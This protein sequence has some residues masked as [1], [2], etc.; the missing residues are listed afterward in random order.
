LD[1]LFSLVSGSHVSRVGFEESPVQPMR[2]ILRFAGPALSVAIS[3]YVGTRIGFLMTPS[4]QPNSTFWPANAILLAAFLLA[5]PRVWWVFVLAVL[6]AHMLA[7]MQSGVPVWT[8]L[9]WFVTNSAEGLFGAFFITRFTHLED[10]F[11]TVRGVFVF[12]VFGVLI[13][14]FVTSFLDAAAVVITGWGHGYWPLGGERFWTNA[15][16]ELTVVPAI[17]LCGLN[18]VLWIRNSDSARRFEAAMLGTS[19]ILVAVYTFGLRSASAA[20]APAVLYLPLPFLLWAAVRFRVAGLSLSLLCITLI[21]MWYTMHG[22][23][24]FPSASMQQNILSLQILFCMVAVPLMFLSV[25]MVEAHRT[26][27]T[28]RGISTKLIDAQEKERSRI[29]RE[30]HDDIAQRLAMLVVQI[31]QLQSKPSEIES[32]LR[33]VCQ[34]TT[35]I[36]Y[37]VQSISHELHTSK[38]EILGVVSSLSS[39]CREFRARHGIEIDFKTDV[40]SVLPVNIGLC[41]LRVLQE[42]LNNAVKHGGVKR[43]QV[44]LVEQSSEVHLTVSDPGKGFDIE[45]ARQGVGLGL[46]SMRERVRLVNGTITIDSKPMSGTT[47]HVR[48]PIPSG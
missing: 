18:G 14:P 21:S 20:A 25:L 22:R 9:G 19:V 2:R 8:A 42:A 5:P 38:L 46:T 40:S 41:L 17:V 7:Q 33:Q 44:V 3:Y 6:P 29:G 23:L 15:L 27:E 36:A 34:E 13:S 1:L 12:L 26:Q 31:N 4:G 24:P 10:Q 16:A 28:L 30:L 45:T 47:I 48:V 32:G 11:E 43:I 37:D 35:E 39:W